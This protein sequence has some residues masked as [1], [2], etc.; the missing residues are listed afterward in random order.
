MGKKEGKIAVVL[1]NMGG[2]DSLKSVKHFLFNLF[3][4]KDMIKA[5]YL[6]QPV[7]AFL[8]SRLRAKK[9]ESYYRLIGGKS[10]LLDITQK[11]GR[12]LHKWLNERKVKNKVYVA[13]RY[14]HPLIDK[15]V[16]EILSDGAKMLI[17]V[18][19]YPHFSLSTTGS[20]FN[21]LKRVLLK[22]NASIPVKFVESYY[23]DRHF[24]DALS[25]RVREGLSFISSASQKDLLIIFSA[26]S[27]PLKVIE[28]GDPYL[29]QI[30]KTVALV[31]ENFEGARHILSF[32]SK[33]PFGRWLEPSTVD[34]IK[35]A[36]T[37]GVKK[38]L[39][40]PVSF[41][42]DNVE[43]LY[44]IDIYLKEIAYKS[45]IENFVKAPLLNDS[46]K[47]IEALGKLVLKELE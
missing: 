43:S 17:A 23:E 12:L 38:I 37:E 46:D 40:V 30:K 2:P 19:M 39:I 21:E 10:P 4:D 13:M 20:G 15:T 9:S 34:V 5:P 3:S 11:Q 36:Q 24:I 1:I 8:I 31:M 33:A 22:E 32:Q 42:S 29:D 47:F 14:W 28:S 16:R 18:P 44:E 6:L 26:H 45:G 25:E 41:T 7:F 27:M 35:N